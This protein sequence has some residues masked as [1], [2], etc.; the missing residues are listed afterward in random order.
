MI[1]PISISR[2]STEGGYV[3]TVGYV[4]AHQVS[5]GS[6][7]S[8]YDLCISKQSPCLCIE[9]SSNCGIITESICYKLAIRLNHIQ[10]TEHPHSLRAGM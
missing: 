3:D 5:L 1:S 2:L 9:L 10:F 7:N 8:I 6:C 4:Q